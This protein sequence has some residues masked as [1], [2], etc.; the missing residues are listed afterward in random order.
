MVVLAGLLG[1]LISA[2]TS[3]IR[4]DI[5]NSN[6]PAELSTHTVTFAR[7]MLS[8]LSAL[9]IT[10]FLTSGLLSFEQL[11]Y[12]LILAIAVVSGFSERL[13]L[14]AVDQVAKTA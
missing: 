5:R 7:L 4:S 1:G 11:N 12:E 8:A 10:L 13:L 2:F 3:T 14:R 9:A 6:I